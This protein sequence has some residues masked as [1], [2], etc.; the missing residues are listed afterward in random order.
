MYVHGYVRIMTF[1][2]VA[3][4]FCLLAVLARIATCKGLHT[5]ARNLMTVAN[6]LRHGVWD[7]S[8]AG[9]VRRARWTV[10]SSFTRGTGRSGFGRSGCCGGSCAATLCRQHGAIDQL[11]NGV[12]LVNS[13]RTLSCYCFLQALGK[14]LCTGTHGDADT[15]Y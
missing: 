4:L 3:R 11:V 14:S 10:R 15:Q 2:G 5:I 8:G 6:H 9:S 12:T 13:Y 7:N 1:D